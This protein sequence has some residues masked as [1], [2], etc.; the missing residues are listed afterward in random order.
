MSDVKLSER[1]VSGLSVAYFVPS[2]DFQ[3][4]DTATVQVARRGEVISLPEWEEDRLEKAG[5]L[6]PKGQ[7]PQQAEEAAQ[8]K[9]DSYRAQ[10][11]DVEAQARS[12]ERAQAGASG[13]ITRSD[14]DVENLQASS[15]SEILKAEKLN[16]DDTVALAESDPDRAR[17]VLEAETLASG[18]TPRAGVESRLSKLIDG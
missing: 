12:L 15:L 11:G 6:A 13:G 17:K 5:T 9:L 14:I 2:K 1:V 7:S 8:A 10:R 18:G 4:N 3:G 16:V